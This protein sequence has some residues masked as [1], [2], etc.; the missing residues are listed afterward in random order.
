MSTSTQNTLADSLANVLPSGQLI[1]RKW[2]SKH[3]FSR[4]AVDYHL[5]ANNLTAL[6]R[7]IYQRP[8]S[9]MK[10]Q[11][12]LHSLSDMGYK[13]HIGGLSALNEQGF[14]HNISLSKPVIQL[15]SSELLP[16]WIDN[17]ENIDTAEFSLE[18]YKLAWLDALPDDLV[19]YSNFGQW[20]WTVYIAHPELAVF[21]YL[22]KLKTV[23]DFKQFDL[24]FENMAT[25]SPYRVQL[26]LSHCT[27]IKAKRLFA[28][29]ATRHAFA[30]VKRIDWDSVDFGSGKRLIIKAGRYDK[31]WRI[32]VPKEMINN[33]KEEG[34]HGSKQSLF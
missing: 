10:W 31:Q 34:N 23:G 17:W 28:W 18:R 24:L 20:D 9:K 30:W 25:L 14:S 8:D 19:T 4:S 13:V 16:R 11:G 26:V 6:V 33:N 5:R 7:G 2:L 22:A 32:T 1:D 15:Y 3:G 29:F 21:E 12:I 27:N